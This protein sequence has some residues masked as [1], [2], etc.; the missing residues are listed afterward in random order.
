MKRTMIVRCFGILSASLVCAML[1]SAVARSQELHPAAIPADLAVPLVPTPVVAEGQ[2]HLIYELHIA[3]FGSAPFTLVSVDVVDGTT[4][5]TLTSYAGDS[6][7]GVLARPGTPGLPDRRV[8]AGG[9]RAVVFIDIYAPVSATAPNLLRHRVTFLPM[10]PPSGPVQSVVTG[11]VMRITHLTP[12]VLG[13]PLCGDGWL[14]SHGLANTSSHRRTLL[15]IDGR[16]RIAQRFAIDWTR[17]EANGQ[18]FHG[19]PSRNTNWTPYGADVLAV[20]DARVVQIVDGVPENDPTSDTKAVPITLE[21]VAGNHLILDLGDGRYALYAHLQPGSFAVKQGARV[22]RGQMLAKLGNSGQ[23][24]APHLHL[25]IMDE[26]SP[27]AAEGL[28][29]VF[30]SFELQGHVPSLRVLTDGTGW[31]PSAPSSTRK[32]EMPVEN[33]V[34]RFSCSGH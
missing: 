13:P 4:G 8:I 31:K 34:V 32:A 28:P 5:A 9:T 16:A 33:A 3:N 2:R 20:A 14:A 12:T 30:S 10:T 1:F 26:P 11:A 18:V 24:D 22:R 7:T 6:L 21:T 17:I 25:H 29:L 23:S 19:D 15:A 27:L